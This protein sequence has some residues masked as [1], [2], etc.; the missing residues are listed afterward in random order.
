MIDG[1]RTIAGMILAAGRGERM[2]PLT[3]TLPKPLLPVLGV[4]LFEIAA[5]KLLRAGAGRILA[6]LHHLPDEIERYAEGRR[7]PVLFHREREILG[8]G[9]GIGNMAPSAAGADCVL[10]H[11]G[12]VVA[13]IDFAPALAFH[14]ARGAL[15]TLVLAPDGPRANVAVAED[16]EVRSIGPGAPAGASLLGYTGLA[17]LAPASLAFFPAGRKG[18][19]VDVLSGMIARRPGSV[20]GWNAG[21]GGAPYAWGDCGSPAP[22]LDVH[23]RIL[24]EKTAFDPLVPPPPGSVHRSADSVVEPGA[25]LA[26]FCEIGR[27]AAIGRDAAVENCVLLEGARV[28]P[29]ER[30]RNEIIFAGGSIR[31]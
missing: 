25:T 2:L 11:N 20:A 23:R 26:G 21:G 27:G 13:D 8:T 9:G 22:Y 31:V 16:G 6:N 17:I 1:R 4:P 3:R 28:A 5:R 30:R 12:D 19:L 18:G 15:V 29:G 7:L 10:L 14:E 24:V